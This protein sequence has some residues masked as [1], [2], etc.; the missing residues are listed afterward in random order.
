MDRPYPYLLRAAVAAIAIG[1]TICAPRPSR[2]STF[3]H[4]LNELIAVGDASLKASQYAT[5]EAAYAEALRLAEQHGGPESERVLAPLL[6]LGKT[7]AGSGHHQEAVPRLQRAV[8]I[9]RA[10]YGLFDLRQQVTLKTL[11][12]SLTTL[13]RVPEAQ[14]LMIYRVRAAEKAYGEGNPKVI[15][16]LCELGD[17]FAEVVMSLEARMTFQVALNIVGSSPSSERPDYR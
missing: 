11:A 5:A 16:V 3:G 8:A 10:Q 12:A 1:F 2:V 17:W 13:D 14:D 4:T 15:P 6:G 7:F 9:M